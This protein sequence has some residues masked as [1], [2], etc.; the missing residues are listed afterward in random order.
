MTIVKPTATAKVPMSFQISQY[1][2]NNPH[3][4]ADAVAK[5]LGT[6]AGYV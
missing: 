4:K 1:V 5:A 6:T 2:K 3:A